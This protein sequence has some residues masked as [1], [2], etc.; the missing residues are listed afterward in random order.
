[1][2]AH[3]LDFTIISA[4]KHMAVKGGR[5]TSPAGNIARQLGQD[6]WREAATELPDHYNVQVNVGG[7]WQNIVYRIN[8][9]E[10]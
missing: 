1:M 8:R 4:P 5:S 7:Y 6:R 9:G 3:K 2:S 10:S